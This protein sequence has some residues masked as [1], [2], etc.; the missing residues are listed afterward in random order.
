MPTETQNAVIFADEKTVTNYVTP[1]KI[2]A[3]VGV[4]AAKKWKEIRK[5]QVDTY[6]CFSLYFIQKFSI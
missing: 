4:T 1:D 5:H 6:N 2:P 3:E